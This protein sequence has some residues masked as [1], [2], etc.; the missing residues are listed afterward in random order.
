MDVRE[1]FP[2]AVT[3]KLRLESEERT[4]QEGRRASVEVLRQERVWCVLGIEESPG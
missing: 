1:D 4:F 3:F 2:V